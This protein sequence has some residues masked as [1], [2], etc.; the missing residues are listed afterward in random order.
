MLNWLV[1]IYFCKMTQ[2]IDTHSLEDLLS[3]TLLSL[4]SHLINYFVSAITP[5]FNF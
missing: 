2:M 4:D 3:W 5:F 1:N